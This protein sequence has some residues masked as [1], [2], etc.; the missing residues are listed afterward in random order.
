MKYT[1]EVQN[2]FSTY[3][4]CFVSYPQRTTP[5]AYQIII[6]IKSEKKKKQIA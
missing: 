5:P 4:G 2:S 1:N 3:E 6:I